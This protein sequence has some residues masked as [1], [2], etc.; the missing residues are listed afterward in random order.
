MIRP[1]NSEEAITLAQ[2]RW[3]ALHNFDIAQETWEQLFAIHAPGDILEAIRATRLTRSKDAA[4]VYSHFEHR[5][6]ELATARAART[7]SLYN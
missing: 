7:Q 5:L 3:A 6:T 1:G 4:I 2:Q